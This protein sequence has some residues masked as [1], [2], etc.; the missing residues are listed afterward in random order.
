ME[1]KRILFIGVG[2]HEYDDYII[3]HLEKQH[4][5]WYVNSIKFRQDHPY[6]MMI[7]K[8]FLPSQ[9]M[10]RIDNNTSKFIEKT[11]HFNFDIVF[12][13][14]GA[15]LTDK[16][17]EDLKRYHKNARFVLYLWDS[18]NRSVINRDFLS[19]NFTNIYS[20]DPLDCEKYGFKHRPLFYID[21]N[22][23]TELSQ[24]NIHSSSD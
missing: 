23:D 18:W 17:I 11:K 13:I 21:K 5:V 20:F 8:R 12:V 9:L 16:H 6:F 22:S 15:N 10:E 2:F 1:K 3:S 14:T 24:V 4:D 19:K 7:A